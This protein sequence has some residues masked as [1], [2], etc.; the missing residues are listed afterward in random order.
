MRRNILTAAILLLGFHSAFSSELVTPESTAH[1]MFDVTSAAFERISKDVFLRTMQSQS[2]KGV[3]KYK[4][5]T[6][7][8][9]DDARPGAHAL[10][11]GASMIVEYN[12]GTTAIIFYYAEYAAI[13]NSDLPYNES[14]WNYM[15]EIAA[16]LTDGHRLT[17]ASLLKKVPPPSV[18]CGVHDLID[19][20]DIQAHQQSIFVE[21][22]V[23]TIAIM[24]GHEVG[25]HLLN[26]FDRRKPSPEESRRIEAEADVFASNLLWH[27]WPRAQSAVIFDYLMKIQ[28]THPFARTARHDIAA[29]RFIYFILDDR[30]FFEENSY[31]SIVKNIRA[32]KDMMHSLADAVSTLNDYA[33]R[34]PDSKCVNTPVYYGIQGP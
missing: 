28:K 23:P 30:R 11:E 12:L 2:Y 17:V 1:R 32:R 13:L 33:M 25:H 9:V 31:N 7:R 24:L 6:F 3:E 15:D 10:R 8:A 29:C 19:R 4:T 20:A 21:T 34:G 22:F 14:C 18:H 5:I 16:T 27:W 26:H